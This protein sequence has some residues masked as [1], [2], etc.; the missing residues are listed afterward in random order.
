MSDIVKLHPQEIAATYW[1][2][3]TDIDM[4]GPKHVSVISQ[5]VFCTITENDVR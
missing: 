3:C 5:S 1:N 2:I 4:L